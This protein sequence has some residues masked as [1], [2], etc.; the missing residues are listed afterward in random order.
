MVG[1]DCSNQEPIAYSQ[2]LFEL[3][4]TLFIATRLNESFVIETERTRHIIDTATH[5]E[6]KFRAMICH[7]Q[8]GSHTRRKAYCI[9]RRSYP[10]I[11]PHLPIACCLLG[12]MPVYDSKDTCELPYQTVKRCRLSR[13]SPFEYCRFLK[14]KSK[15]LVS[16]LLFCSILLIL[17]LA[18]AFTW[19]LWN[20]FRPRIQK[21]QGLGIINTPVRYLSH[22]AASDPPHAVPVSEI[23]WFN[24]DGTPLSYK[25][26]A[27]DPPEPNARS[28]ITKHG[29]RVACWPSTGGIWIKHANLLDMNFLDLD[30]FEDTPRQPDHAAEDEF[31]TRLRLVGAD[32]WRFPLRLENKKNE[33]CNT[34]ETCFEPDIKNKYLFAWPE[35]QM[36]ACYVSIASAEN[37]DGELLGG[38][39]HATNMRERCYAIERLKGK[40]CYCKEQCPDIAD[41]DWGFRDPGRGCV[42]DWGSIIE[43][44][45]S[46][47]HPPMT[48]EVIEWADAW[49]RRNGW[50]RDVRW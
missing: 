27:S 10:P 47:F 22:Q 41:F 44:D 24:P 36:I 35:D 8:V 13:V 40:N 9:M 50:T 29:A 14:M 37:L 19:K 34:L 23:V 31:C 18:S 28:T 21:S 5:S 16:T 33:T 2:S 20:P 45:E 25:T 46:A 43:N 39:H 11:G 15:L 12:W 49:C 3:L 38:Y 26:W 30:R 48:K 17:P 7:W 42:S 4:Q 32:W 1:I 6:N